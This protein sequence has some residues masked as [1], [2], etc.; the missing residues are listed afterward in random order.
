MDRRDAIKYT[1]ILMGTTLSASTLAAIISGCTVD[2]SEKW[3][4]V[5]FTPEEAQF[6]R[7]LSETMLPK[8]KTPGGKDALVDRYLDTI[9]P[10]RYTQEENQK[11]KEDLIAF[12]FKAKS[13]LG[14]D[15]TRVSED[16]RLIWLGKIDKEAF[17]VIK[18]KPDMPKEERPFY[19]SLK[20][21]ILGG[22]FSS[23]VVAKE[24]FAYD[25]IPGKFIGCM[26]YEEVGKAW[27]I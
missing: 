16:Q 19:L 22:Y 24:Y 8:T 23:E 17:D 2:A 21:L 7:E 15:F 5:F 11:F 10:L 13:D 6:I 25:P 12:I 26:P 4:P 14:K 3:K 27:A 18:E 1:T 9:R 20:E